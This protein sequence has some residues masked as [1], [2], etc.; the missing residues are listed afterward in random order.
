MSSMAFNIRI[1]LHKSNIKITENRKLNSLKHLYECSQEKFK[2][3]P[4]YQTNDYTSHQ[5]KEKVL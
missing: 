3:M 5:I 2:I 4:I 1:S